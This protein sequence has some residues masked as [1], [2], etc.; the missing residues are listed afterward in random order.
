MTRATNIDLPLATRFS[1]RVAVIHVCIAGR[2]FDVPLTSLDIGPE[3]DDGLI[4]RSIATRL[5]VTPERLTAFVIDRH[6]DGNLTIRPEEKVC[7]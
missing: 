2:S 4:K 3:S 1:H 6:D 7:V 5:L